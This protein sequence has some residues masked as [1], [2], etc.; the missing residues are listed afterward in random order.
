[1]MFSEILTEFYPTFFYI[2]MNDSRNYIYV[3]G[4]TASR[5]GYVVKLRPDLGMS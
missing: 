3:C 5:H 4:K 1:M 2:M